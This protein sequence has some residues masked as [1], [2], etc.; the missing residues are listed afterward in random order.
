[1]IKELIT[2]RYSSDMVSLLPSCRCGLTKGE[3]SK[4][5][6]CIHCNT[7]VMSAIDNDLESSVWFR[8]PN[9]VAKLINPEIWM[10]LTDKFK[11][12]R[13]SLLNWIVDTKYDP[14]TKKPIAIINKMIDNGIQQGYNYFVDNFDSIMDFM[15][16]LSEFNSKSASNQHNRLHELIKLNRH[17]IFSDYIPIPNKSILLI[18]KTV[19]STYVDASITSALNAIQTL[20]SIDR[21]FHDQNQRAKENRT[22][23]AFSML[24]DFYKN[25][26]GDNVASKT[27]QFRRHVLGSR[28]N[29]SFRAVITSITGTHDYRDIE[30]PWGIGLTVLREHLLNKLTKMGMSMNSGVA[31]IYSHIEKYN[32]MLDDLLKEIIAE[33]PGGKISLLLNRNPSLLQGSILALNAPRV[34]TDP[35]DRTIGL[36]ILC[37]KSLN[38]D[39]DGR[40]HCRHKT[41]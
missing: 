40:L 22:A 36:S 5:T 21:D 7:P 33:F 1:M 19:F 31:M 20:V 15:F 30:I 6:I 3:F 16:S 23:R 25:Y 11:K 17:I 35:K 4:K 8:K 41:S 32:P 10:M 12:G 38:A 26:F 28:T 24:C 37:V 2:T 9:G 14:S 18:E 13:Y 34:K 27:G 29:F 39:F